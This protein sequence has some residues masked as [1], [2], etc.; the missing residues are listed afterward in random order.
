MLSALTG[1]INAKLNMNR[2]LR[3]AGRIFKT[4]YDSQV[5]ITQK[6]RPRQKNCGAFE[7]GVIS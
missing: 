7:V 4:M 1:L 5:Q 2:K 6:K 3:K